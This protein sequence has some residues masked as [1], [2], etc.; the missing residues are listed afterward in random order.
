MRPYLCDH[1]FC[2]SESYPGVRSENR[3]WRSA[4]LFPLKL[5]VRENVRHE[6]EK[7]SCKVGK[8]AVE[9]V[10]LLGNLD[11]KSRDNGRRAT[12]L[13]VEIERYTDGFC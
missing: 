13:I 9:S 5:M 12:F 10:C 11:C 7:S 8:L 3:Q 1:Q 6:V 4:A 2:R